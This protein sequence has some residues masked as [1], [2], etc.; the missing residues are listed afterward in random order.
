MKDILKQW[1]KAMDKE[2][3]DKL[4]DLYRMY[5]DVIK[6]AIE[7]MEADPEYKPHITTQRSI[8]TA[9]G[10]FSSFS[11]SDYTV[12]I[13]PAGEFNRR[14]PNPE[15]CINA[16]RESILP[17]IHTISWSV[18]RGSEHPVEGTLVEAV[19][20]RDSELT[21]YAH[22]L[23][24]T[25]NQSALRINVRIIGQNEYGLAAYKDFKGLTITSSGQALSVDDLAAEITHSFVASAMTPWIPLTTVRREG[26][27]A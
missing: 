9:P 18:C 8:R 4:E 5:P 17:T 26:N 20:D 23:Y 13:I 21:E 14:Y 15:D 6:N 22:H 11:G 27:N 2:I 1:R 12:G 10:S 3:T 24:G 7:M 25:S 19:F 16:I